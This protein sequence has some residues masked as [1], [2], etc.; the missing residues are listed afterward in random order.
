M[1]KK[2]N[3]VIDSALILAMIFSFVLTVIIL[4]IN[5][6]DPVD[7]EIQA[8][9]DWGSQSKTISDRTA[10]N[11]SNIWDTAIIFILVFL[12]AAAIVSSLFIDTKPAFFIFSLIG[13]VFVMITAMSIEQSYEDTIAD[14]DYSTIE[15]TYP[16]VHFMME[17]I[18]YV[19]LV[20]AFSIAAVLYGKG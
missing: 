17:N 10:S 14:D 1:K 16:K 18:V 4:K 12:W 9:D 20:I 6:I 7:T 15:T 5:V 3:A 11:F 8:D 2:G 13:I 19:I